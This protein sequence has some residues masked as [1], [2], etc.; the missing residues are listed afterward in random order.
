M[1]DPPMSTDEINAVGA[2]KDHPHWE[3]DPEARLVLQ[4]TDELRSDCFVSDATWEALSEFFSFEQK[5]DLMG[6]VGQYTLV[7]YMLNTFGVQL[8]AGRTPWPGFRPDMGQ[9]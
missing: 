9:A 4:M 2:G 5:V 6:T 8:E 1:V 3:D 7:S